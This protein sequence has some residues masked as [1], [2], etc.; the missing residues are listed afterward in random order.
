MEII[1]EMIRC[2]RKRGRI[3]FQH[4]N[5]DNREFGKTVGQYDCKFSCSSDLNDSESSFGANISLKDINY[6]CRTE[7]LNLIAIHPYNIFMNNAAIGHSVGTKK[8]KQFENKFRNTKW[9]KN[10]YDFLLWFEEEI[11]Q[12]LPYYMSHNIMII[13]D[14]I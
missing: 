14:K 8:F 9:A 11:V 6:L 4:Q 1:Y 5:K 10:V 13:L 7:N 12:F 3:I 2:V